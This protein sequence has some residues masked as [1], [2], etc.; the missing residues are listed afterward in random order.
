MTLKQYFGLVDVQARMALKAD[1]SRYFLGYLWWIMEPLLYVALFYVVFNVILGSRRADF[2]IFLLCGKLPFLWFSKSVTQASNSI[3][4]N[5]GLI[6]RIDVPK[7]LFPMAVIQEGVYK[8]ASVFVLL[9]SVVLAYDYQPGW[10]WLWVGPIIVV[11]YLMIVGCGFLASILV[12]FLRDFSVVIPLGMIFLM[13]TSGIF[14]DVRALADPR[15]TDLILAANPI[16]F[17]VDAY[18]QVLMEGVA[19]Q[20]THLVTVACGSCLLIAAT[21]SFFRGSSKLLSLKV[22]TA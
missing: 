1:A 5:A 13:F 11:N 8:E 22:L 10:V 19:P 18:R 9:I 7:S 3:I 14:W 2:L 16:A 15:M 17:I 4:S 12:C 6:G 20:V 21:V